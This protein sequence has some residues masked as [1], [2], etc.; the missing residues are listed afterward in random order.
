MKIKKILYGLAIASATVSPISAQTTV[1]YVSPS[2]D[3]TTGPGQ[4]LI[5][6]AEALDKMDG[7][8]FFSATPPAHNDPAAF[9]RILSDQVVLAPDYL[10]VTPAT[11]M[12]DIYDRLSEA[13]AKGTELIIFSPLL[14][15]LIFSFNSLTVFKI[16]TAQSFCWS[17]AINP[18]NV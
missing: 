15:T 11:S 8:K 17:F 9:D 12:D 2:S 7:F 13:S 4:T 10:M 5:G 18:L 3:I 14:Q 16:S 1:S 6:V